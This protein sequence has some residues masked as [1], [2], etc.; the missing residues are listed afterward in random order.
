METARVQLGVERGH[1]IMR[2]PPKARGV[3]S[4]TVVRAFAQVGNTEDRTWDHDFADLAPR[5]E[6]L[7]VDARDAQGRGAVLRA[8][9]ACNRGTV[10]HVANLERRGRY[11]DVVRVLDT[12]MVFLCGWDIDPPLPLPSDLVEIVRGERSTFAVGVPDGRGVVLGL[13]AGKAAA[14]ARGVPGLALPV[15]LDF[16]SAPRDTVVIRRDPEGGLV[17][18]D[19]TAA[20]RVA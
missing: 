20:Q 19:E 13:D 15:G 5:G 4:Y 9:L 16:T 1:P 14:S 2:R 3:G 10:E 17:V 7:C 12:A 11:K 18:G 8:R 6:A